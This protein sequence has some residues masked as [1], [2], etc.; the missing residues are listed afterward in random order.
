MKTLLIALLCTGPLLAAQEPILLNNP[1]FEDAPAHGTSPKG[2]QSCGFDGETPPD[3]Q[4]GQNGRDPF[5]GVTQTP[6]DGQ[7]YL[8]MV[9]RDN[10]T[11][12]SVSSKLDAP[13]QKGIAYQFGLFL[14]QSAQYISQSRSTYKEANYDALVILRIWGGMKTCADE[15]LL[16]ESPPIDHNDWREYTFTLLPEDHWKVIR[17]EA[18]YD[19][20]SGGSP[21]NSNL[22]ADHCSPLKP[23]QAGDP[24]A[25]PAKAASPTPAPTAKKMVDNTPAGNA[26]QTAPAPGP[27]PSPLFTEAE[28]SVMPPDQLEEYLAWWFEQSNP[29]TGHAGLVYR[30]RSFEEQVIEKG[31]VAVIEPLSFSDFGALVKDLNS[32]GAEKTLQL[33]EQVGRISR[34]PQ[35]SRKEDE[36]AFYLGA[37]DVFMENSGS[38]SLQQLRHDY[39]EDHLDEIAKELGLK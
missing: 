10:N 15:Q 6:Y 2:W 25:S 12:E 24:A 32:M 1:S 20:L 39:I 26:S 14:C 30:I 22:L 19:P 28:L 37:D 34:K 5:F 31:L 16:A 36:Q 23:L 18:W 13:L 7:T 11:W 35:A 38:E 4:P 27:K 17:L 8:G 3:I 33:V 29:Q 21:A 9:T